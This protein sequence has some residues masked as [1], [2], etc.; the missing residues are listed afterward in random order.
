MI[1]G[2]IEAQALALLSLALMAGKGVASVTPLSVLGH[3]CAY[4]QCH[5]TL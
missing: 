2:S 1:A 4:Y 3:S 5:A